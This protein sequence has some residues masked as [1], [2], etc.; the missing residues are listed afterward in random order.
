MPNRTRT[1]A[2]RDA[3]V[4][5]TGSAHGDAAP[6]LKRY[7]ALAGISERAA[8]NHR[9]PTKAHGA[10]LDRH[11]DYLD[12]LDD[13]ERALVASKV[14]VMNRTLRHLTNEQL[15]AEIRDLYASDARGEA[16]DNATRLDCN[17]SAMER[18]VIHERDASHDE[19]LA[20]RWREV[21]A[22]RL[23]PADVFGRRA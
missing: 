7:A 5:A 20:A 11:H 12:T 14:H 10:P 4:Y 22:R 2:R 1:E 6:R 21:A 3:E 23:T 17:V 9:S 15:F 19:K 18:A 8:R 16:E 13:P